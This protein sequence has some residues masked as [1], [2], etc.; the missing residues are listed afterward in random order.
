MSLW[1]VARVF[2]V[3]VKALQGCSGWLCNVFQFVLLV[4]T[5]SWLLMCGYVGNRVLWVV[6]K[7]VVGDGKFCDLLRFC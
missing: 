7:C 1:V 6:A 5:F 2:W 3:L 4:I